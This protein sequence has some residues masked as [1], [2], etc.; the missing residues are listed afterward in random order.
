MSIDFR[1]NAGLY[2]GSDSS[3]SSGRRWRI[4]RTVTGWRLEFIDPGDAG[5]TNA[6]LHATV[7]AAQA[8]ANRAMRK[9][10]RR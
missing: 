6:G 5:P 7:A 1:E 9:N 4:T 2:V 8:E 10:R 3:D